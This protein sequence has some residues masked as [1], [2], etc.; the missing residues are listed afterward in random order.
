MPR[1]APFAIVLMLTGCG[2]SP[3]RTSTVEKKSETKPPAD[4]S[5]L[6]PLTGLVNSRVVADH[7]LGKNY[8]PGGTVADYEKGYQLFALRES[9]AQQA[10]F[11][12]LDFK[13]DLTNPKYLAHMGGF[14]GADAGKPF[15][16]FAKGP[17][18]AGVT[19][20]PYEKADIV[21]RQFAAKIR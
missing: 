11:L 10:A 12:L 5:R 2:A 9:S 21:A 7:L 15:Y 3:P 8:L 17:V 18:V 20:L 4:E 19:G 1:I 16:V 13:K 14:F 6:F